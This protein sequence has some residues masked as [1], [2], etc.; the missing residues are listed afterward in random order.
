[1]VDTGFIEAT[2]KIVLAGTPFVVEK[3]VET[4][5]NMYPGRLVKRDTG[6]NQV[7]VN[8]AKN[9]APYGWLG[10]EHSPIEYRPATK[11]TIYK[12]NDRA[13]VVFGPIVLRAKL[14]VSQTII[15]GDKLVGAADGALSKATQINVEA[16]T[17]A[18]VTSSAANGEIIDGSMGEE[19]PIVAEAL[20][21]VTTTSAIANIIVRSLI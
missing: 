21:S 13:A 10:Y 14:A 11:D 12:V 9:A 8:T 18:T 17:S 15:M 4:V 16:S 1:M 3:E 7:E 19:G 5:A 6:D 20:E 2:D